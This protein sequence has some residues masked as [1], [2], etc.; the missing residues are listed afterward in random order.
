[1]N[2]E[3]REYR[4]YFTDNIS[5]E[6]LA[7]LIDKTLKFEKNRK[8]R[9][10]RVHLLKII[11]AVAAFALIIGAVNI[12]PGIIGGTDMLV[13][14]E[15]DIYDVYTVDEDSAN[16]TNTIGTSDSVEISIDENGYVYVVSETEETEETEDFAFG[17]LGELIGSDGFD[18]LGENILDNNTDMSDMSEW[19]TFDVGENTMY[20]AST[21][22]TLYAL[23]KNDFMR[24]IQE[25]T[26][27]WEEFRVKM[28]EV[29]AAIEHK[30]I[31][32]KNG[33]ITIDGKNIYD[34]FNEYIENNE[35]EFMPNIHTLKNGTAIETG[36]YNMI[37]GNY[38][39]ES[40]SEVMP[41][42]LK[43]FKFKFKNDKSGAYG[44]LMPM[45]ISTVT[46]ANG[47]VIETPAGTMFVITDN[48]HELQQII[49]GSGD[50][51]IT[52]PD[53]TKITAE[54]GAVIDFENGEIINGN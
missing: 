6:T 1:M 51:V 39:L 15:A 32:H 50:A 13:G 30:L 11:P 21:W 10:I 53:G 9:D 41:D 24:K 45:H 38:K 33:D 28:D 52:Y 44:L 31:F 40:D 37:C 25:G 4:E 7:K 23:V 34:K 49:I 29:L 20:G 26:M 43:S 18:N 12:L 2:K 46:L 8:N 36:N 19:Y 17:D 48:L 22:E 3:Y 14:N 47:T 54:Y 35:F 27:T 16:T 42:C 5:D